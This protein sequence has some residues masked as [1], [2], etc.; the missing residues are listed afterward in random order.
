MIKFNEEK[1]E[2][3]LNDKKLMRVTTLLAKHGLST[4]YSK[5]PDFILNE[6]A[7]YSKTIHDQ[8]SDFFKGKSTDLWEE[9]SQ[10]IKLIQDQ[11]EVIAT[12]KIVYNDDIAGKFDLLAIDK[13]GYYIL[14][15]IKMTYQLNKNSVAWQLSLYEY[16]LG[17]ECRKLKAL[18][19]NPQSKLFE[20]VEVDKIYKEN[21][22]KLLSYE[23]EG[24]LYSER[25]DIVD[26]FYKNKMYEVLKEI[27]RLENIRKMISESILESMENA[28][29]K[30]IEN[31]LFK[32]TYVA[33][34]VRKSI[35]YKKFIEDE[36]IEVPLKYGKE[37]AVKSSVRITLKKQVKEIELDE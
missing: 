22:D 28:D 13:E 15:D 36:K 19:F 12:E 29:I 32:I 14:I 11:Y 7:N 8:I 17:T 2:Y 27:E 10:A 31:D 3:T 20:W 23:K 24:K 26:E 18:W 33:P 5:V 34:S 25:M 6:K 21:I 37:S 9:S 35:D 4:D 1:Q 30:S 16:L